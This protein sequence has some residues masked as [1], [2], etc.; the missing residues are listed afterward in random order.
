LI[1]VD[2]TLF[3]LPKKV[4]INQV[5]QKLK[6]DHQMDLEIESNVSGFLGVHVERDRTTGS[7]TLTQHGLTK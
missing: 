2:D 5:I 4:Y 1:Y 7:I 3:F 6:V